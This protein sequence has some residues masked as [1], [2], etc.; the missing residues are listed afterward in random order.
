MATV[1][2][3]LTDPT[4]GLMPHLDTTQSDDFAVLHV[5]PYG[6][7]LPGLLDPNAASSGFQ[8]SGMTDLTLEP[9][10]PQRVPILLGKIAPLT[11]PENRQAVY[12]MAHKVAAEVLQWAECAE[13]VQQYPRMRWE[14]KLE[15]S[16][17]VASSRSNAWWWVI[18]WQIELEGYFDVP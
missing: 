12:E 7:Q 2:Q 8:V 10:V 13:G 4:I 9:G 3:L 18:R 5:Q 6:F 14:I 1:F 17:D 16:R 11:T 15:Q